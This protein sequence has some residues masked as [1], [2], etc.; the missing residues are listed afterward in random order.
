MPIPLCATCGTEFAPGAPP[1]ICPIC[2]DARQYVRPSGQAWTGQEALSAT[3]RNAFKQEE[4]G[5]I[6]IGIEPKFAIGQRALLVRTPGGNVLWDCIPLVD[7]ATCAIVEALGGLTAIAISHPHYYSG[8]ISWSDALGGV[9]ILLH[10]ADR[11]WV[12][13]EGETIRFWS[14]ET[15]EVVPGVT[16]IRAGGHFAGGTVCHWADGAEGRGVL[17]SGDILQ[18]TPG[19]DAV[20]FM[21]SY[22]NY[23]PLSAAMVRRITDRVGPY[24]FDRI[25]GAFWGLTIQ[26]DAETVVARSAARY[27]EAI[28][29]RGPADA[30][31]DAVS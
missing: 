28:E 6:G 11:A 16:L 5:L 29:G 4:P 3:H 7:A 31:E 20:S 25:H 19:N 8:M 10:D 24:R 27:I 17:L 2:S 23:V 21:R 13:R 26:A 30:E 15:L 18:V 22:P 9:P 1:V 14:G 12:M